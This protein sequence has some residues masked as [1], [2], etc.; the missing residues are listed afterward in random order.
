MPF[1]PARKLAFMKSNN[2]SA[3]VSP[4]LS[5][6][7]SSSYSRYRNM[8]EH[9]LSSTNAASHLQVTNKCTKSSAYSREHECEKHMHAFA[10]TTRNKSHHDSLKR[11]LMLQEVERTLFQNLIDPSSTRL[12]H[13]EGNPNPRVRNDGVGL[14]RDK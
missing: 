10:P 13:V 7:H 4:T 8:T 14:R 2:V 6:P 3:M 9:M 1:G 11:S 12:P 5:M